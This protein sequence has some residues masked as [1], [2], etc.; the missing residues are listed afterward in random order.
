MKFVIE[1]NELLGALTVTDRIV[2]RRNTIPILGHVLLSTAKAAIAVTGTDM[3]RFVTL[4]VP[5]SSIGRKGATTVNA[6]NLTAFVR[7]AADGGQIEIEQAGERLTVRA[8]RARATLPTLPATDFPVVPTD[9]FRH[10]VDVAGSAIAASAKRVAHCMSNEETRYYLN[11]AYMHAHDGAL[12]LVA[13]DGHKLAWARLPTEDKVPEAWP[14]AIVPRMAIHDLQAF[15]ADA[16]TPLTLEVNEHRL[17]VSLEHT[18]YVTRLV[19]GTFPDYERVIPRDNDS[20]FQ[21]PRAEIEQALARCAAVISGNAKEKA[22]KAVR[23]TLGESTAQLSRKD[24]DSG[25]VE[26]E[27]D[28]GARGKKPNETGFNSTYMAT[29][30]AAIEGPVVDVEFTPGGPL[31]IRDPADKDQQL[32]VVMAMRA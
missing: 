27:V 19:D 10:R 14:G 29:A 13:T 26:D 12:R 17:K 8:G 28:V 6:Q 32:Q 16:G 31:L 7:A 11:G 5:A 24:A 21:T 4:E 1:R 2:A 25:D 22:T 9:D 15:G 30:L 3:D 18:S 20:G 23:L